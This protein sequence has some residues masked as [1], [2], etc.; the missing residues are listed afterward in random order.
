MATAIFFNGRR[1]VQPQ[2]VSRVDA[3]ALS[4]TSPAATGIVGLIGTAEGGV[5]LTCDEQYD[6]TTPDAANDQYRSGDLRTAALFCFSPSQDTLVPGG[7]QKIVPI[8]VNPATQSTATLPDALAAASVDLTSIGYGQ[9]TEQENIDV[10]DGTT[11]G[12]LI[13]IIF[14]GTTETFDD[15]GGEPI[16]DVLYTP[17]ADGYSTALGSITS[18]RFLVTATK[19]EIGLVTERSADIAAPGVLEYLSSDV[20][21][22]TQT[23][24]VY[25]LVG[26]VATVETIVLT[27]TTV[28]TG[29]AIFTTVLG[30]VKSAATIGTVT[31]RST[32]PTTLF[33]LAPATLTRGM[34]MTNATPV[35]DGVITAS[36]DVNAAVDVIVIGL[37][38]AGAVVMQKYDMTAG[39][40]PIVGTVVMRSITAIALGDVAAARTITLSVTAVSALHST[41][42]T[43][44]RLVDR[45]NN[46]DGFTANATAADADE[47]LTADADYLTAASLLTAVDFTADLYRFIEAINDGSQFMTAARATGAT[48][49]PANTSSPVFLSGGTEG[50]TTITQWQQAFRLL[51]KRRVNTI[52]PLTSDSAVHALLL[53]HLIE[54]AGVLRSEANGYV[55]IGNSDDEGETLANFRAQ[56][57]QLNTRHISAIS[58]EP[59]R[60]DPLTGEA[61]WF[62]PYMLAAI[63]AGMQAGSAV[64][65][66]LTRKII[67]VLDIRNDASWTR[68]DD[69]D[70]LIDS[71]CMIAE[72]VDNVGI[73]W[74]RSVTTHL[75]DDNAVFTE[76]SANE[77]ANVA[78]FELRGALDAKVGNRGLASS[79]GVIKGLAAAALEQLVTDQKIAA[80]R[81]KT[82]TVEQ[83]GDVFPVSVEIAPILP[84][85]FIPI[86]VHLVPLRAAA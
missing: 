72:K 9:F 32:V 13:T 36:I 21:D 50:T 15:V 23:V 57:R 77:S 18:T 33:S 39:A 55:G 74:V 79:V 3:T 58:E 30:A 51:K 41:F 61:T 8:K 53:T 84:I 52:V 37:S 14:E 68:E 5:P 31:V 60:F 20:G 24:K 70:L 65:E 38:A 67:N 49:V 10:A 46:L 27:G 16:F 62:P 76:M 54:R 2:A 66:P 80:W 83:I 25:G 86:T 69:A 12:K 44:Q 82:L 78:V 75:Q 40:T 56:V 73:R 45:L 22:I 64:G 85:N 29:T 81:P 35:A 43:V 11:V 1:I 19:A 48:R 63:A 28:V 42:P 17:G 26:G 4:D 6:L 7:A 59:Q 34:V 71:G 47:L